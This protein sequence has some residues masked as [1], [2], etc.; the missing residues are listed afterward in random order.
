MVAGNKCYFFW[1]V[2]LFWT[3]NVITAC[4]WLLIP[5]LRGQRATCWPNVS[6]THCFTKKCRVCDRDTGRKIQSSQSES[7]QTACIPGEG[8]RRPGRLQSLACSCCWCTC[9]SSTHSWSG[10]TG[11]QTF[12]LNVIIKLAKTTNIF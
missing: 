12:I 5:S 10:R 7:S 4:F 2:V 3:L 6:I 11:K 9:S 8:S 1:Q